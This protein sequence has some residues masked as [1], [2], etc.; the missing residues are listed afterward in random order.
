M[1]IEE[2]LAQ[3]LNGNAALNARI[4][5]RSY[6]GILPQNVDYPAVA[7]RTVGR[8]SIMTLADGRSELVKKTIRCFSADKGPG[9]YESPKLVDDLLTKAIE[10]FAGTVINATVSP[11]ESMEIQGIFALPGAAADG[12][13]DRT[14]TDQVISEFEIWGVEPVS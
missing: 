12:Y 3:L 14:Q 7:F 10:G 2:A 8:E 4:D 1:L 13:D 6:P 11:V 9:N 5:G